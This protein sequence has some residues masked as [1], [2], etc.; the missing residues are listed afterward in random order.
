MMVEKTQSNDKACHQSKLQHTVW[1]KSY[2]QLLL[3]KF[4]LSFL[5]R[6]GKNADPL[7]SA[8][9]KRF[10]KKC[11]PG[12]MSNFPLGESFAL[13]VWIK[14]P[15]FVF[16]DLQMHFPVFST[17]L[18]ETLAHVMERDKALRGL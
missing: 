13:G 12:G 7:L 3:L 2:L 17:G 6:Q 1:R 16:F 14:I 11:Y 15:R 10:S 18:R 8:G 9:W 4:C 5:F